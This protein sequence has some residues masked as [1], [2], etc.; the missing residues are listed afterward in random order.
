MNKIV[1]TTGSYN[2]LTIAH[3]DL[4]KAAMRLVYADHGYFIITNKSY[5]RRKMMT[6]KHPS[7]FILSEEVRKQCVDTLNGENISF[8][9]IELGNESPSTERTFRKF[10]K[11]HKGSDIYFAIGAD[12]LSGFPH[13]RDIASLLENI[14]LIVYSRGDIDINSIIDGSSVLSK[15]K[16]KIIA[17][18]VDGY[19]D[20]SST[21]V[22]SRFYSGDD[23]SDL[24][25]PAVYEIISKFTPSD[26]PEP[27]PEDIAKA[28]IEVG[29][30]FGEAT[31]RNFIRGANMQIYS[32]GHPHIAELA[33]STKVYSTEIFPVSSNNYDTVTDV[34]NADCIDTAESLVAQGYK[35]AIHNLASAYSP[36][37]GYHKGTNAQE[38]SLCY[39][40]TLPLSL[41][42]FSNPIRARNY[43][44]KYTPN[45]YPL[46]ENYGGVYTGNVIFFRNGIDKRFS[47][48][49]NPF[50]CSVIT[51]A[52]LANRGYKEYCTDNSEFFNSDDTLNARG[53]EVEKNKIRTIFNLAIDNGIDTIVTG[54]FGCG[55]YHLLPSDVSRLYKEVLEEDRYKHAFKLVVFSILEHQKRGVVTGKDGKYKPFYDMFAQ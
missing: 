22:R 13:W 49:E 18:D 31:A 7:S 17:L 9:G 47:L 37:G 19:D 45:V 55:V 44:L 12:K 33:S 3:V 10:Q 39:A 36:C 20:V 35:V 28:Y 48:R 30:R 8:G 14:H 6:S 24:L 1:V 51:V 15:Y 32:K 38:E 41:Y 42:Q 53:I 40:S 16:H 27:T 34:V 52:S 5:L 29:G 25:T 2:P 11:E 4:L 26:F 46:D 23:Y 21:L 43:G 54:A 50:K